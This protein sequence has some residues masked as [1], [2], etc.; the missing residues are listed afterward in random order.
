[1]ELY[2]TLDMNCIWVIYY[3]SWSM[4]HRLY[5]PGNP[6]DM[7]YIIWVGIF[8]GIEVNKIDASD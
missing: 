2:F 6:Y 5:D 8:Y 3:E 4:T 7:A 1:M